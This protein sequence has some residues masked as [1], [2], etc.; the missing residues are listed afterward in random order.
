MVLPVTIFTSCR[1]LSPL[2]YVAVIDVAPNPDED[3]SALS[4]AGALVG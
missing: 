4:D 2:R 1:E 3:R